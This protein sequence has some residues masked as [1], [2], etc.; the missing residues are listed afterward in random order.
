MH[1]GGLTI[2]ADGTG[3]MNWPN[4]VPP[5]GQQQSAVISVQATG[6]VTA[7]ATI[8]S[9]Q[10]QDSTATYG[11][12]TSIYLQLAPPGIETSFGGGP[13]Y[14]FCDQANAQQS[15]CGA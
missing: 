11:P 14:N 3:T 1:D 10:L 7:A 15:V 9:G 6:P 8:I 13:A 4:T 5:L 12:G 2:N